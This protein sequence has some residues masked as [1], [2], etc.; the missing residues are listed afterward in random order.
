MGRIGYVDDE[1]SSVRLREHL[2]AMP[3]NIHSKQL[4]KVGTL[5]RL[6]TATSGFDV[7][8]QAPVVK[9][10][11]RIR[12]ISSDLP[13]S[14]QRHAGQFLTRQAMIDGEQA[15][16]QSVLQPCLCIHRTT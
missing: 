13:E 7:P 12:S 1:A 4:F 5:H 15:A 8:L 6:E 9:V 16:G 10:A 14:M 3:C 11:L 2:Q